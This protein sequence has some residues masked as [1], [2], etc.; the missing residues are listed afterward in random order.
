LIL[1]LDSSSIVKLYVDEEHS[2]ET[3]RAAE[4]ADRLAASFIAYVEVKAAFARHRREQRIRTRQYQRLSDEFESDWPEYHAL[5]VTEAVIRAAA[6]LVSTH[7]LSGY[8]AVHL[9]SALSLAAQT[10][11]DLG[12]SSWD[13]QLVRAAEAEGLSLAHEVTP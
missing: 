2:A 7:A 5:T 10:P 9:A 8:D 4:A 11:E 12:L 1:Y 6:D 3:R 13:S